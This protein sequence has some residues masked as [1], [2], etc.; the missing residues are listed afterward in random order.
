METYSTSEAATKC[1]VHHI[2]LQRWISEGKVKA[3]QKTRVGGVVVRL[4]TD[5]DVERV[6]KYK[7]TH[8]RKGRGRKKG[9]KFK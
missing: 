4:W 9:N 1:G 6:R 2:T 7:A 5:S 8:Y 3:P